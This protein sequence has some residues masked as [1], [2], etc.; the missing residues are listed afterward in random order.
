MLLKF[1]WRW[2][3][4]KSI[5]VHK[6][7]NS[8]E[9]VLAAASALMIEGK[10][11][12]AIDKYHKYLEIDPYNVIALNDLGVCLANI[13]DMQEAH[14]LF[15]LAY[16]MDDSYTPAV[17][18]HASFLIDQKQSIEGLFYLKSARALDP[19]FSHINAVY[20]RLCL[21][22]R[23]DVKAARH[24]QLRAW[25]AD[26]DNLRLANSYL[27]YS[28]YDDIDERLLA[29]EHRFW[30]ETLRPIKKQATTEARGKKSSE[31]FRIGYWSPD[32]RNHSVRY[33]FRPLQENHNREKFEIFIYHDSPFSDGQTDHIKEACDEFNSVFEL[34]DD[35]LMNLMQS[36][37]LDILV[38][39]AGHT[40]HNRATLLQER[41]ATVQ[42]TALGYPPTT[43]LGTVDV[44]LLDRYLLTDDAP[45][46]YSEM[47]LV[48]PTS[49]WCFDPIEEEPAA[50]A[51]DP[52]VVR[53]GYVTFGCV[54][55]I[56][57][58]N[59]RILVC[60]REIMRRVPRS[61]LL[62][63]AINFDDAA[64]EPALYN[65]FQ[66][67]GLPMERVDLC[68]AEGGKAYFESYNDIDIILDTNPFNGGTTTCFA[69]YMGV[70]VVTWAGKSLISRMGL[71]IMSNM[72]APELVVTDADEYVRRS[73]TLSQDVT[74]LRRFKQEARQRLRQ[75]GLGNGQ[76]FAKEFEQACI[77]L[78]VQKATG[79]LGYV[80]QIDVL[81]AEEM[82]RRA[83]GALGYD[84]GDAAQRIL[85]Y[86]LRHYPNCGSAHILFTSTMEGERR[87][88]QAATY[89]LE[90][91]DRFND[92]DR[93]AA[94]VNVAR[95]QILADLLDQAYDTVQQF[96]DFV[97]KNVF[98]QCQ[99]QLYQARFAQPLS[100]TTS[101][102][103]LPIKGR[104]C[105]L[106]PCD[107]LSRFEI[108]CKQLQS[109][110][111]PVLGWEIIYERCEEHQRVAA[112]RAACARSDINV[113]LLLQKNIDIYEPLF[114]QEL[115]T[116]LEKYDVVGYAGAT[117]WKILDWTTDAFEFKAGG[118]MIPSTEK[119]GFFE[120]M[121]LG[122][123]KLCL[124]DGIAVLDGGLLAMNRAALSL[125]DC[126][127]NLLGAE[128]LLEQMWSYKI[129]CAGGKLAVHRNL[130]VMVRQEISLDRR[131]CASVRTEIAEKHKFDLFQMKNPDMAFVSIPTSSIKQAIEILNVYFQE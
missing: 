9:D 12:E 64:A 43:G 67:A 105:C 34:T 106:I 120:V 52:P 6:S 131:Y 29:A 26:F 113:L 112:Y 68:K 45:Y 80:S 79:S 74:Y 114:F 107:D 39:L 82:V 46:Y 51:T 66:I 75:T 84:Q 55:N 110:C 65:R 119:I 90:R 17:V 40:S 23:G 93:C 71:S 81:P 24:F 54:G 13:G 58:I 96:A 10:L 94:L 78:L 38:E 4:K 48:L 8:Q 3:K 99:V 53:N 30:A 91:L 102:K 61:R 116:A 47:P 2:I 111:L 98:D 97:P 36:H 56:A 44:K 129:Q 22:Y 77:E 83:Y 100:L 1:I 21:N 20:A 35:S 27:F 88:E 11:R 62:I 117:R 76:I 108:M 89:L 85:T 7:E 86:C 16:C 122:A 50:L 59:E 14:R 101:K 60:W 92:E 125:A 127:A 42:I 70:P 123:G 41:L 109:I 57:K 15:G 130:G 128:T 103:T 126:D 115:V 118:F 69:V 63:R 37:Q 31:K 25:V 73:V 33:F 121:L 19:K 124:Q 32:F 28:S 18:N 104:L 49:F 5:G 72:G 95:N 87:F